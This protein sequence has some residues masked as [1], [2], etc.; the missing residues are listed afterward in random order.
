MIKKLVVLKLDGNFDQGFRVGLSIG[1]DGSIPNVELS[2]NELKLPPL[3]TLPEIYQDWSKS[4]RSLDGHR[5]KAKKGQITHVRFQSVKQECHHQAEIIKQSFITWLQ[6]DSFRLI[7]EQCLT[8]LTPGDEVR[9]IIRTTE[10]QLRKLPWHLWDLFESYPHAEV[11]FSSLSSERFNRSERS[12]IRIL[13]ILGNSEGI[14]V[15][16]DEE[17]LKEYCQKAEII[18]LVEPSA[19]ELNHHLWDNQGWGILFF[20]G[21]SRTESAKGRIFLNRT[22]SLTMEEL[23][24]GLQTAVRGGLQLAFFNSCD[25]LGIAAEL[26]SLHIPEVIVMR[27]PVPDMV[28]HQFVK[29]FFQEFTTGQ[30]LYQ[31]VNIARKKLQGLEKDYPCASWLP[32]IV[33][34]LLEMPP[35]WQSMGAISNCPYQ[36]LAAFREEDTRYFYGREEITQKLVTA[37]KQKHLVAVVG[38]SGSGKSSVVFAGL[39]PELKQDRKHDWLIISFR[40]GNNPLE[41]LAM[42]MPAAGI[43]L[44]GRV[45]SRLPR[46][47]ELELE[48]ELKKSDVYDGLHL[49]TL[50]NVIE[51]ITQA[52]PK[53]HLVL[54]ADQFEEL[55]TLCQDIKERQIFLDNLLNAVAN[56]PRFTLVLTLRADFFGE[57]LAYR[58]LSNALQDAQVNLSPMNTEELAAAIEKPADSFNVQLE[59]GLTQRLIDVVLQSPS[60]LPLLEF[61]LTQLWQKQRQGWLTHLAYT[62]IGGVE[63]ALANHAEAI[64]AQLSPTDKERVQQIFIQLVQPTDTNTDI[65]RLAIRQEVGEE[66]WNLVTRLADARLVV[67]NRNEINKIETVEI[68]HET[69]IKNWR[70]LR[71]WMKVDAEFRLWQ[72][73]L[74]AA[75]RQWENSGKDVDAFWRGKALIDAEEWL[76]QRSNQISIPEQNFINLSVELRDREQEKIN[77]LR[78]K[79][80][81]GLAGGLVGTLLL[82]SVALWQWQQAD[83]QR[84]QAEISELKSLSSSA[85][86]LLKSGNEV[87]SFVSALRVIEKLQKLKY[88]DFGTKITLLTSAESTINQIREYNSLQGHEGSVSS[89]S[90]SP[91]GQILASGSQDSTIKIWQKNGRLLQTLKGHKDH[92]FQVIFSTDGQ[93]MAAAS[94]DNTISCWRYNSQTGLFAEQPFL[95]LSDQSGLWAVALSHNGRI[96]ATANQKGQ[97]KLWTIEGKLIQT[98]QAHSQ[99]IWS[100][101]FSPDGQSFATASADKTVKLWTLEGKLIKTLQGHSDEVLSV[102]FSPDGTNLASASKDKT[103]KLWN[104]AGELLDTFEGHSD[105]VL[106]VRFSPDGKLIAS[107]SADDTVKLWNI[108]GDSRIGKNQSPVNDS[109][110]YTFSG[111]GGK[112]SEVSFSPDGR[113]L[114]SASADGTIKLW[115][116]EGIL[117]HFPGNTI[118]ISPNSKTIAVG[119]QQGIVTIRNRNGNLLQSFQA[120]NGEI[121][122]VIFNPRGKSLVSVG[123]DNQI[124]LWDLSGNLLKSW[125][126]YEIINNSQFDPIA[127]A[128][129]SHDGQILATMGRI[130]K[131]VKLWNLEGIL[132]KSWR[133]HDNLLTSIKFSPDGK[134]LATAGD[135]T[136][137][138]WNIQGSLLQTLSGHQ[139]NI[140]AISFS[141]D[142]KLVATASVDNTVKLWQSD[143]GKLL[144]SLKH[145][146]SVYSVS[147]SPNNQVLVSASGDKINLWSLD[148][149][150]LNS[151]KGNSDII[152]EI[153][154]SPDGNIIAS[155]GVNHIVIWNLDISDLQ[156]H[157]CNW[158]HDYLTTNQNL[159]K[160]E[161][162]LC[163]NS[164]D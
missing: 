31:S 66:N 136:V 163:D 99:K 51:S 29:D 63:I 78:K 108:S 37:V 82:T 101:S 164:T 62:D 73:Q 117:P 95:R 10:H 97:V 121:I 133:T 135:K 162:H 74:R 32:V 156:H 64:Y 151:F 120:H 87:E 53:S 14:N 54:V 129:F 124:K 132:L 143:T 98:I 55:Y 116:L 61:T 39:I 123:K 105:E 146:E 36:G 85:E 103:V 20:S 126:G 149:K 65:R 1:E 72:E 119:N 17:V 131:Q 67:T 27:E 80:L 130:D 89:V 77:K 33:Q 41:S 45:E 68:I 71:Q 7:K 88:L 157:G 161:G 2:D 115:H 92:V 60:H 107:A 155:V 22:E 5:I 114:A 94:F 160:T 112:A 15:A 43:A 127:D 109:P 18:V 79:I 93:I 56:I 134:T 159:D 46:L 24:H 3:P 102:N 19:A 59:P 152:S 128:S 96:I 106:D 110:L 81:L 30:S 13:I 91:D 28:A 111:H 153:N 12:N 48:V 141:P 150:L 35:T 44:C 50:Q 52:S 4:Y 25:G 140:A 23:R 58:P 49:R 83:F 8:Q 90:F 144:R 86:V 138:L 34:N 118:S 145:D 47:A 147:F 26:E 104:I 9:V 70:R 11:A 42:A 154:F 75:I 142:G 38:A 148:G 113:S 76:L 16:E 158:L 139:D 137:K 6:A 100:I 125:Q 122:K 69:L 84:Q 57:A 21:H 40:P